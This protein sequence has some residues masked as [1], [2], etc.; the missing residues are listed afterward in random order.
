MPANHKKAPDMVIIPQQTAS[1]GKAQPEGKRTLSTCN[2][3]GGVFSSGKE[4]KGLCGGVYINTSHKQSRRLTQPEGKRTL[5]RWKLNNQRGMALMTALL[6]TVL[7]AILVAVLAKR[8]GFLAG[9]FRDHTVKSQSMYTAESGVSAAKYFLLEE[10]CIPP[11]FAMI[12]KQGQSVSLDEND[13]TNITGLIG[14]VFQTEQPEFNLAGER[15]KINLQDSS[16]V[17]NGR[18]NSRYEVY[19]KKVNSMPN[20]INLVV[21][22][23]RDDN[24]ANNKSNTVID[25]GLVH[26]A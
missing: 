4:S 3:K 11:T 14:D 16:I 23:K 26:A 22:S 20:V 9:S 25:V 19:A 10:N 8:A 17:H 15:F 6:L 21:V 13:L 12:D 24:N 2:R 1:A 7:I 18:E 5:S